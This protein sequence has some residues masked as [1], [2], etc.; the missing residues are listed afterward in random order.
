ME[1][2]SRNQYALTSLEEDKGQQ[3]WDSRNRANPLHTTLQLL[4]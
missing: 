2:L 3:S 1:T 4:S